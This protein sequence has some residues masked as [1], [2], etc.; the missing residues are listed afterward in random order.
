MT[1]DD[2]LSLMAHIVSTWDIQ[3]L[4]PIKD[5]RNQ[6]KKAKKKGDYSGEQSPICYLKKASLH[7]DITQAEILIGQDIVDRL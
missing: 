1:M 7:W 5:F 6:L 4:I 3:R 2:N